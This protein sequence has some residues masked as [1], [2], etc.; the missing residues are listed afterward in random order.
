MCEIHLQKTA[1]KLISSSFLVT[2]HLYNSS[3][4][5]HQSQPRCSKV[6]A[7]ALAVLCLP[8]GNQAQSKSLV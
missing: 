3:L 5:S 8:T 6:P 4:S 1:E 2:Q 7:P